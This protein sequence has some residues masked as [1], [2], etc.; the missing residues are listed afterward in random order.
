MKNPMRYALPLSLW[1]ASVIVA[2]CAGGAGTVAVDNGV[3]TRICDYLYGIEYDEFNF[4]EA[5]K[6]FDRFNPAAAGCSEVRKGDFVGRNLD[7]NINMEASAIIKMNATKDRYASIGMV[8][9]NPLFTEDLAA[10]GKYDPVYE[11]LPLNTVDGV[12][13]NGV[14]IGVNVMPT[15]ETS[16]D[17]SSW[18]SGEWGHGAAYTNPESEMTYCVTYLVRV[19]LDRAESV[20]DAKEI[21]ESI[22]WY[23]PY[24]FPSEGHVQA[25][26]WLICDA[27]TS[28]VLE[29]IDNKPFY[30]ESSRVSKPSYATVMTNFTNRL[31][32]EQGLMQTSGA[33]YERWDTLVDNYD[34]AK[35]TF[36]SMENLMEKVWYSKCYTLPYDSHEL[37]LTEFSGQEYPS[38]YLYKHYEYEEDALL[39]RKM[40]SL[41]E[42]FNDKSNWH[43]DDTEFWYT[44]H[45]SVYSLSGREME[46]LVHE[47]YD[48]QKSYFRASLA[49]ST[50]AKP[51]GASE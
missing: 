23:E 40:D 30:T 26:H 9:C 24:G 35:G 7:W 1:L 22:N 29:F 25:F 20:G 5:K 51:L 39:I 46:V 41:R 38:Y 31:M 32:Y 34:D 16:F 27:A 21:I 45:T 48:T 8:G 2:S 12:N 11:V 49:G 37:M 19:V 13:E 4:S 36:E 6:A 3:N 47:G 50:F 15:G 42:R 33:G 17:K 43:K 44:T 14:Y 28:C 10:S 18:K